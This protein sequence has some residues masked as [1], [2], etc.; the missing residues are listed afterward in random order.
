[1][2]TDVKV[3][4]NTKFI[5]TSGEEIFTTVLK[6]DIAAKQSYEFIEDAVLKNP[7]L[8]SCESPVMYS[9][10]TSI[11]NNGKLIS[12][13]TNTFGIRKI[14][15]DVNNGFQLKMQTN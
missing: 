11:Y 4:I 2:A 7:T 14:S 3:G 13:D 8:W 12:N 5:N 9:A 10:V 15:I 1:M 6:H